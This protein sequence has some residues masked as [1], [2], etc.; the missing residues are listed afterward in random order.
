MNN[1]VTIEELKNVIALRDLPDEHLEWI[2]SRSEYEEFEDGQMM[3]KTG[4]PAEFMAF[5]LEGKFNFYMDI[6]GKLVFYISFENN[7]TNGGVTGILPYSRM[8]TSPGNSYAVGKT[9]VIKLHKKYFPD[10]EKLNPEFIQKLIGYMTERARFFATVRMQQEK[11]S[12]LGKLAAG[13]AHEMN[14]PAAAIDRISDELNK[15]LRLNIELTEALLNHDISPEYM[16]NI[17]EMAVDQRKNHTLKKRLTPMQKMQKE[18]ELNDWLDDNGFNANTEIAETFA[19]TGFTRDD[20]ESLKN[21]IDNEAFQSILDWMENLLSSELL[22]N[23]L[24]DASGRITELVSAI[25]SHVHMDR[26]GALHVTDIHKDIEDTLI[27]LGYKI[28]DKH[29]KVVK[30]FCDDMPGVEAYSGELNQVWTNLI[31]NAIYAVSDAG[32]IEIETV[33]DSKTVTVSVVD[34]GTGIPKD[35][36]SRVFDPFFTTKKVGEGTGIGLDLV[37]SVIERHNGDVKVNSV[38]GRTEFVISFPVAQHSL[39]EN[40]K[41]ETSLHYS[42]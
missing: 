32:E 4:D 21:G 29:I 27:L 26:S 30:K 33:C 6:N 34:N 37:K 38:K 42:S 19:E 31:D 12:A 13:I 9:R 14:N 2:L 22:I 3:F 39:K 18:D 35:I 23:D 20:L 16:R 10:L 11:V 41:D 5:V 24:E 15:R 25:K 1:P 40:Q 36:V 17:R 7:D 8:K 28:R